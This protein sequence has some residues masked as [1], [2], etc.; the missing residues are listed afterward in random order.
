MRAERWPILVPRDASRIEG[1]VDRMFHR[2]C[3]TPGC[4]RGVGANRACL[5]PVGAPA[6][7][8]RKTSDG[9]GSAVWRRCARSRRGADTALLY[10]NCVSK[11]IGR[12]TGSLGRE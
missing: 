10:A 11:A 9:K 2:P 3:P 5:Y 12:A 1:L 4:R 7:I 8:E 6:P